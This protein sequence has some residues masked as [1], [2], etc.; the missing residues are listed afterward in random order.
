MII[1]YLKDG[2]YIESELCFETF[3]GEEKVTS[4]HGI[5]PKHIVI[6][7]ALRNYNEQANRISF[8]KWYSVCLFVVVSP[9]L[10][11]RMGWELPGYLRLIFHICITRFNNSVTHE[12]SVSIRF[13]LCETIMACFLLG[14]LFNSLTAGIVLVGQFW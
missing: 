2:L 3:L 13:L 12:I 4:D 5:G 11:R 14:R 7:Q 1:L 8:L 6:A 9:S 10:W